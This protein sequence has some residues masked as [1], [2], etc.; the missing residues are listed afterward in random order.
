M[1]VRKLKE[2]ELLDFSGTQKLKARKLKAQR[3]KG[4]D[5]NGNKVDSDT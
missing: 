3:I 1:G 2:P 4:A 5:L